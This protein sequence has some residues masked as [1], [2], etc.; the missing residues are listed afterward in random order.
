[1]DVNMDDEQ[2][3]K[4]PALDRFEADIHDWEEALNRIRSAIDYAETTLDPNGF[5]AARKEI[6]GILQEIENARHFI[7]VK[8]AA[9]KQLVVRKVTADVEALFDET[10]RLEAL[11][12]DPRL[13]DGDIH[14]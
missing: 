7:R 14:A 5:I 10:A 9:A 12:E 6:A 1:M 11:P 3:A 13:A 4:I 2:L 8:H